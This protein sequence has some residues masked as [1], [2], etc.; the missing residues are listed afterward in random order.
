M[1]KVL[2]L[3]SFIVVC[4]MVYCGYKWEKWCLY[5]LNYESFWGNIFVLFFEVEMI[6]NL[7]VNLRC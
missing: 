6:R 7:L 1:L 4:K 2:V 5:L 3:V